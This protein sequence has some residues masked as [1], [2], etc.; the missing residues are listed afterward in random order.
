MCGGA[1]VSVSLESDVYLL[2]IV[3][4]YILKLYHLKGSLKM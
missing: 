4:W 1:K 2:A 3:V